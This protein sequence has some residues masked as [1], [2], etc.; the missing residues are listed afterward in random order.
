MCV[1]LNRSTMAVEER[2]R[3]GALSA[4]LRTLRHEVGEVRA[5]AARAVGEIGH[6]AARNPK[7]VLHLFRSLND[8]NRLVRHEVAQALSAMMAQGV[9]FFERRRNKIE[10]RAIEEL[11]SLEP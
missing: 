8:P 10:A 11:V 1:D 4:L 5:A 7:I 6:H 2:D 3:A 9:R